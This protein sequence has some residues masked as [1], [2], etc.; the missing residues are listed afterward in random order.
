MII[1]Y[2]FS[3]IGKSHIKK[4]T[5][6]QDSHA[7][8]ELE[9]GWT[10]AV[11]GDGVGSAKNSEKGSQIAVEA[12]VSFCEQFFPWDGSL[13]SV[14]S[15]LRTAYNFALKEIIRE[16]K[17]SKEPLDSY[18]TTLTTVLYDGSR[19]VYAHSG[20][21]GI[22]GLNTFGDY[23]LITKPQKG[24]DG[25]SVIPLRFG[26][27]KWVIDTYEED[28]SAVLLVTDGMLDILTP[29]LLRNNENNLDGIYIPLA[30]FFLDP[31]GFL[32]DNSLHNIIQSINDFAKNGVDYN[33]LEFYSRLRSIYTA[34]IPD[35]ANSVVE[36]ISNTN[37]PVSLMESVR[38]D[39]T[40][41]AIINNTMPIDIKEPEY[42]AEP[43]WQQ[44]QEAWNRIAYPHLYAHEQSDNLQTGQNQVT[45]DQSSVINVTK[46]SSENEVEISSST[47]DS[48]EH[49]GI[50]GTI[51]NIKKFFNN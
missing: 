31:R 29:Y 20:D 41:V 1:K 13:L 30:T 27:S 12:V 21:G 7:I 38:D 48:F 10:V 43:D 26:D 3:I 40:I 35:D 28:L 44:K 23:F 45:D 11:V 16:S 18:D 33:S 32:D 51:K 42:Y 36:T 25:I 22:I 24:K 19:I 14:K 39:K 37:V 6:C 47:N 9:N 15:M 5:C 2:G 8:K 4:G 34:I 46:D 50:K 17:T 49:N